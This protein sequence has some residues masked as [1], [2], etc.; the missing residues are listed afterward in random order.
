MSSRRGSRG[1]VR[2]Q[3]ARLLCE[4]VHIFRDGMQ[5][6]REKTCGGVSI[7]ARLFPTAYT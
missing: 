2:D 6:G 1:Y 5:R 7:V 3:E 4:G